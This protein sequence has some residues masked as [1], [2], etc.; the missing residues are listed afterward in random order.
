MKIERAQRR[1][2]REVIAPG[3]E[4]GKTERTAAPAPF[5]DQLLLKR[6]TDLRGELNSLIAQIDA[7]A[8]TI[9]KSLTFESLE[10]YRELV[11]KFIHIAVHEL[12]SVEEKLSVSQTGKQKSLIIVK[13]INTALEEL[14][15]DCLSK[16]VNLIN[17]MA[18]IDQIRGLLIDLYS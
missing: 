12:Y 5:L 14:T 7:Q 6:R 4:R 1:K 11:Q 13:K 18:R 3:T 17:F 10:A 2:P 9:E 8:K 15:N 16:Q